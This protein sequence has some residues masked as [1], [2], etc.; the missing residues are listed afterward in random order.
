VATK[1][2]DD[3]LP[4][5][6]HYAKCGGVSLKELNRLEKFLL[7]TL[8][9]RLQISTHMYAAYETAITSIERL[10]QDGEGER[11]VQKADALIKRVRELDAKAESEA[12]TNT[13]AEPSTE[14]SET[15]TVNSEDE[16]Y[17]TKS[18]APKATQASM[19]STKIVATSAPTEVRPQHD[20]ASSGYPMDGNGGTPTGA[21]SASEHYKIQTTEVQ[22]VAPLTNV[23]WRHQQTLQTLQPAAPKSACPLLHSE[24]SQ[25]SWSSNSVPAYPG[26]PL[27]TSQNCLTRSAVIINCH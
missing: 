20:P 9:F 10:G 12:S 16:N 21:K 11:I 13:S 18:S 23:Q 27:H 1:F 4:L 6:A 5:N 15:S 19:F 22:V 25:L 17:N 7:K 14:D 24:V 8:G 3:A 26:L 2:W